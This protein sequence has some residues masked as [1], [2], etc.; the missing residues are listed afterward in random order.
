MTKRPA[1]IFIFIG[2]ILLISSITPDVR[3]EYIVK[4]LS[5]DTDPSQ[6]D[7]I[8]TPL[9]N[10]TSKPNITFGTLLDMYNTATVSVYPNWDYSYNSSDS[11]YPD[12]SDSAYLE[13]SQAAKIKYFLKLLESRSKPDNADANQPDN[14]QTLTNSEPTPTLHPILQKIIDDEKRKKLEEELNL[15]L[16]TQNQE[17]TPENFAQRTENLEQNDKN[18]INNKISVTS[19][20]TNYQLPIISSTTN[21][22]QPFITPPSSTFNPQ[23]SSQKSSYIIALLGDSMTDTIGRGLPDL[24]NMLKQYFPDKQFTLLNYGQGSTDLDSGVYRLT[25]KSFYLGAVYPP[26]LTYKPDILVVE[27]FAY[28]HWTNTQHDL[29]RQWLTYAKIIDIVK[30]ESPQTK[31]IMAASIAPD[32][33][34]FGDGSLNWPMSLKWDSTQTTKAYLLNAT[35]F[36]ASQNL[37]LADAYHPSLDDKNNGLSTYINP[38]D[39]I[40]P[41]AEGARFFSEKIVDTIKQYNMIE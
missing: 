27:S 17:P 25:H 2:I 3:A 26:V 4:N 38:G 36:A 12:S 37:P 29:D 35:R 10:Q 1:V 21:N 15:G 33:F 30:K 24:K 39:H 34:S 13:S 41:S 9:E 6:A 8:L 40:H 28:N 19:P 14:I 5:G 32:S 18:Q 20:I 23:P 31:I 16:R 22:I 7:F 11:A